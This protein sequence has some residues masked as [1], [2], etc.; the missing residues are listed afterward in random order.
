[1]AGINIDQIKKLR[2]E[3]GA[4]VVEVKK[5]LEEA[6]GNEEKVKEILRQSGFT[7]A[8]KK[9]DRQIK[10]GRIFS[11]IHHSGTVGAMVALGCETDFVARTDEFQTLG[12]EL[13]MQAA[14]MQPENK[15]EF[16]KQDYIRDPSKNIETLIKEV[17]AKTGENCQLLDF[18]RFEV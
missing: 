2:E 12:R 3:T 16:L 9:A 8:D 13:A 11:Y 18:K 17:V 5:A 6:G 7:R 1:M 4:G 10:A 15:D 14:S